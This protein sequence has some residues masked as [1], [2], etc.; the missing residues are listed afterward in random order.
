MWYLNADA[1]LPFV[2]QCANWAILLG[3]G[4]YVLGQSADDSEHVVAVAALSLGSAFVLLSTNYELLFFAGLC[5][6]LVCW[7]R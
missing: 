4:F 7:M 5:T 3:S 2:N 6:I 1:G